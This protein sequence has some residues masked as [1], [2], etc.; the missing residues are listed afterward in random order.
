[1]NYTDANRIKTANRLR[2]LREVNNLSHET[3]SETLKKRYRKG[4]S[5]ATLKGLE[6]ISTA[7]KRFDKGFGTR[8]DTMCMLADFYGVSVAYLLGETDTKSPDVN[9][10]VVTEYTGLSE[11]AIETLRHQPYNMGYTDD[12]FKPLRKQNSNEVILRKE[13]LDVLAEQSDIYA[14]VINAILEKHPSLLTELAYFVYIDEF[15]KVESPQFT[16]GHKTYTAS[17]PPD[18]AQTACLENVKDE[19]RILRHIIEEERKGKNGK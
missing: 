5:V 10:E 1:M 7:D 18:A 2:T 14:T 12:R 15:P 19:V 4:I 13:D 11:G 8:I 9:M 3:L 17:I 16:V 6:V